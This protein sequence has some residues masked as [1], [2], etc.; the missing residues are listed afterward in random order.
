MHIGYPCYWCHNYFYS[1][2]YIY[3]SN[4]S[5]HSEA[6]GSKVERS[7][8]ALEHRDDQHCEVKQVVVVAPVAQRLRIHLRTD[9]I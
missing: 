1:N 7:Q 5:Q 6:S 8:D 3:T 4:D 2:M 9:C